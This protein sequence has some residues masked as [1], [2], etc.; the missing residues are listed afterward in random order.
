MKKDGWRRDI[1]INYQ[2]YLLC[3]PIIILFL[4]FEYGPMYGVQIAFKDFNPAQGITGSPWIGFE[5]F[6]RFFRSNMF[7]TLLKNTLGISLYQLVAG[8]PFPVILAILINEIGRLKFRKALQMISY[9]PHF[10]TTVAIVGMLNIFL[11]PSTGLLNNLI[12][13]LGGE[14]IYFL[15]K[16]EWFKSIFVISGIWQNVGWGS[17]IYVAVLTGVDPEL[18]DSAVIDGANR[19]QKI[20]YIDIPSL[21]PTMV[22]LLIMNCGRVMNVS[23][24]KVLLMQNALNRPTSEV[25]ST[26]VYRMGLIQHDFSFASA[27]GLFNSIVNLILLV[28][29][30]TISRNVSENSLW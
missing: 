27:V 7:F 3:L 6:A 12:A 17:I 26:Y 2:L 18:Y 29:V 21:I 28:S 23:F 14:R 9:A 25:I 15:A 8:F 22:I 16:P 19:L 24:E 11:T 20:W 4:I 5:N 13:A 30:N 1:K 10:I